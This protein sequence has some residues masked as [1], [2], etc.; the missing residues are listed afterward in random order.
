MSS[1]E[2]IYFS[3]PFLHQFT[4]RV[5]AHAAWSGAPSLVLDR[6]AF[7]PLIDH[8]R[9]RVHMALHTGQHMLG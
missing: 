4:G 2:R 8:D 7:Y 6:T 9:R 5:I 1:T 3:D